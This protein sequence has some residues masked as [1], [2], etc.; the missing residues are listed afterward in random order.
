MTLFEFERQIFA[1]ALASPVCDV[2]VVVRVTPTSI[3]L[4][5]EI[6]TGGFIDI[7][8]NEQTGTTA[9][10]LIRYGKR[11]FGADN[12]GGWHIHP[13]ENPSRHDPLVTPM[14]FVDF[15]AEI[16]LRKI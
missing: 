15:V 5:I 6:A 4:R 14:S 2:P 1:V 12:T 13:L 7:F 9:F 3:K 8:Y 10:A 11:I 16:E